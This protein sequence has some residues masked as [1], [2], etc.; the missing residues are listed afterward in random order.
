[1]RFSAPRPRRFRIAAAMLFVW[2]FALIS[3]IA[4]ACLAQPRGEPARASAHAHTAAPAAMAQLGRHAAVAAEHGL[5]AAA[6]A[7]FD[8]PADNAPCLKACDETSQTL[9]KEA[10][11]ADP[12]D[13]QPLALPGAPWCSAPSHAAGAPRRTFAGGA[14]R[15]SR[16]LRVQFSRLAL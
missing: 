12:A 7:P 9:L 5:P 6:A 11:R 1:M 10:P 8:A 13:Q 15:P 2:V 16:P 14:G 3:G 4:N